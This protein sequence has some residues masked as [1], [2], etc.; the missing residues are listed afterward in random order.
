MR[1][2]F[3]VYS[4]QIK[5]PAKKDICWWVLF[6]DLVQWSIQF[7]EMVDGCTGWAV[8]CSDDESL[9][10][11]QVHFYPSDLALCVKPWLWFRYDIVPCGYKDTP[12]I[13]SSVS[14]RGIVVL[15]QKFTIIDGSV[16]FGLDCYED[17]RVHGAQHVL[18]LCFLPF[19]TVAVCN[20][21]K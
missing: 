17:I 11:M 9:C 19:N 15:G 16:S 6:T 8:V 4:T 5:V 18:Q 13:Q 20:Y 3:P 12:S 7:V 1:Q 14:A 10:C 2:V 21:H